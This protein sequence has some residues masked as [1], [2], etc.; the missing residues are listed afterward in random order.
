M[1]SQ[2]IAEITAQSAAARKTGPLKN[3]TDESLKSKLNVLTSDFDDM[4]SEVKE[5][6]TGNGFGSAE[7][8][9]KFGAIQQVSSDKVT[10]VQKIVSELNSRESISPY[11]SK[12]SSFEFAG[13]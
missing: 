9:E 4:L 8:Q 3:V 2:R 6:R 13:I 10:A 7:N 11:C 1:H 12:V 5:M